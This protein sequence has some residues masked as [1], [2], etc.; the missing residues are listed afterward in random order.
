MTTIKSYNG[1][2]SEGETNKKLL[3]KG[4]GN[5]SSCTSIQNVYSMVVLVVFSD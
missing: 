5:C 1:G 3:F 2:C 4:L